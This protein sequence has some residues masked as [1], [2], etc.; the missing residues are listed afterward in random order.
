MIVN[1][2]KF[3]YGGFTS[4]HGDQ[5]CASCHVFGDLDNLAWDLGDPAGDFQ[6]APPGMIDPA[7]EGF[8]PDEGTDGDAE[9]ARSARHRDSSTGAAIAPTSPRSTP[10]SSA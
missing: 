3:F 7:L 6:T 10:P 4:A 9:P 2:R 8:D 5:S 1:G